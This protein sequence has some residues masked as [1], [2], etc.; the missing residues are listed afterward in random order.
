MA[1]WKC[2]YTL[3]FLNLSW[4]SLEDVESRSREQPVFWFYFIRFDALQTSR[5]S[6][7]SMRLS[8]ASL[9]VCNDIGWVAVQESGN[10]L[11]HKR[12]VK[13]LLGSVFG[14]NQRRI[15]EHFVSTLVGVFFAH[16]NIRIRNINFLNSLSVDIATWFCYDILSKRFYSDCAFKDTSMISE[17]PYFYVYVNILI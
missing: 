14:R 9:S 11:A 15:F 12:I 8:W 2:E 17:N 4:Q 16:V 1:K 5:W 10:M 7:D 6:K 3:L 13:L